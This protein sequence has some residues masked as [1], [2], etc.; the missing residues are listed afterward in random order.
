MLYQEVPCSSPSPSII[1]GSRIFDLSQG[2]EASLVHRRFI[3]LSF[4]E[5][6]ERL[7][8]RWR[9]SGRDALKPSLLCNAFRYDWETVV[10]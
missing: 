5:A 2:R 3:A 8:H 1:V 4:H 9:K 10:R 7:G 6:P